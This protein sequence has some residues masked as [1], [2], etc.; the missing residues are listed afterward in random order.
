M[1]NFAEV[2]FFDSIG[3]AYSGQTV[4]EKGMGGSEFQIVLLAEELAK[5]G[6]RV[7]CFNGSE[8]PIVFNGVL[9]T[10]YN[11]YNNW[12]CSNLIIV[13]FSSVPKIP[14]KKAFVWATDLN[15]AHYLHLYDILEQKKAS[16]VCLSNF[17][18]DLFPERFDKH[19]INF[20]IPDWVYDLPRVA[21]DKYYIYCSSIM[22]GLNHT[23]EHWNF[24]Q[25]RGLVDD[26]EL[27]ICLPGYD[28]PDRF[29][30]D[31]D[32]GI[33]YIGSL[34]FNDV[35]ATLNRSK[36]VFY[37]NA[38][39]ETFCLSVALARALRIPTYVYCLNGFGSLK[40]IDKGRFI[41]DKQDEFIEFFPNEIF[42]E[43]PSE[44]YFPKRLTNEWMNTLV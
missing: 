23:I 6:K 27:K 40:E 25:K 43:A 2:I 14:H 19:V 4:S 41:T 11:N 18:S 3:G 24:I 17:Q 39:Q 37:V 33:S 22:K 5:L 13:R 9:Y 29:N 8:K 21:K 38:V 36:G 32:N 16:L 28:T 34:P 26:H 1:S 7:V 20:M 31:K 42:T 12:K 30:L 35:V 15:G 44:T 10:N